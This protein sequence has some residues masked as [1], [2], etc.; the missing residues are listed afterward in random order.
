MAWG[1]RVGLTL[2]AI[3]VSRKSFARGVITLTISQQKT[4]TFTIGNRIF[5]FFKILISAFKKIVLN[6]KLDFTI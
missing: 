4:L 3:N 5:N 2:Q 1:A 6:Y